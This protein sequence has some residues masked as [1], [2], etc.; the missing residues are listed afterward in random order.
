MKRANEIGPFAPISVRIIWINSEFAT[1]LCPLDFLEDCAYVF[2]PSLFLFFTSPHACFVFNP[3]LSAPLP[4]TVVRASPILSACA[5]C[6]A[7]NIFRS[8]LFRNR[9]V[10]IEGGSRDLRSEQARTD[11]ISQRAS[12]S[13]RKNMRPD[14]R[15]E[16]RNHSLRSIAA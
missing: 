9:L 5:D 12:G 15:R 13:E 7:R 11:G 16:P 6:A 14:L 3:E 10:A 8:D 4:P 1:A 2:L